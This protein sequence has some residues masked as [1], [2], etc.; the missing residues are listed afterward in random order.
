M[1]KLCMTLPSRRILIT[2]S[3]A[4]ITVL[5]CSLSSLLFS[6]PLYVR[7]AVL[8]DLNGDGFLDVYVVV[9]RDGEPYERIPS[10]LLFNDGAGGFT[11]SSQSFEFV[12]SASAAVGDLDGDGDIDLLANEYHLLMQYRNDGSG[13][14]HDL[15]WISNEDL[16]AGRLYLSLADLD[17]NG[18]LDIFAAACCGGIANDSQPLYP[19][20]TVWLNDGKGNFRSTGQ[21]LSKMGS[22]AVALGDVDGDGFPDAFVAT[23]QSIDANLNHPRDNPN[24]I[25]LNDGQGSFRDSGQRLGK[26]ESLAVALGDLDGDGFIDA[27]VGNKGPDEVWLNDGKG[28]YAVSSQSLGDGSARSVHLADLDSDGDL[29]IFIAEELDGRAW[30]NDGRGNFTASLQRINYGRHDAVAVGD[31]DGD[32]Q[33]DVLVVGLNYDRLWRNDGSGLFTADARSKYR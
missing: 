33:V 13:A 5:G 10:Y 14:L 27:V 31:I 25:W 21:L 4:V 11:D 12:H 19:F 17:A 8:A 32:G 22:N 23:G 18:T 9:M 20:D 24:T 6:S 1:S 16:V 7:Q 2:I 30:L 29:D 26:R 28:N 3:L 15:G